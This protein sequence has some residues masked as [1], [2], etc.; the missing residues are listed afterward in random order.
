MLPVK[1]YGWID[2]FSGI[3]NGQYCLQS[4][5]V[6]FQDIMSDENRSDISF[7]FALLHSV[8]I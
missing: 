5:Q 4:T 1:Y 6:S 3:I 8:N 2:E 7:D